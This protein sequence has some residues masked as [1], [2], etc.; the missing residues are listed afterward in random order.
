MFKEGKMLLT[1]YAPGLCVEA[2]RAVT[3][4]GFQVSPDCHEMDLSFLTR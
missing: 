2:V 1:E 3:E 4:A